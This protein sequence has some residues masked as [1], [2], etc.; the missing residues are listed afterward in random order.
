MQEAYR[1]AASNSSKSVSQANVQHD[2]KA[3]SIT[4]LPGDRVL[5]KN[6]E[7]GGQV[8]FVLTWNRQFTEL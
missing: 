5:A 4:L 1:I 6:F 3:H 7:K 2:K 8:R